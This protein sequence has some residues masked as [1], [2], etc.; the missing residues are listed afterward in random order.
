M[1]ANPD[2]IIGEKWRVAEEVRI[3]PAVVQ[4]NDAEPHVLH[5]MNLKV[6][7]LSKFSK[8]VRFHSP[9][10]K[11]FSLKVKN[12]D[13]PI[14][15]GLDVTV[16]VEYYTEDFE[17]R[18]DRTILLVDDD[19][20]EIPLIAFTPS[21][22]LEIRGAVDFG[23]TVLNGKIL[24]GYFSIDNYGS[25]EGA[26]SI[27]YTGKQSLTIIP[28]SDVIRAHSSLKIKVEFIGKTC[29]KFQ[30]IINVDL[31]R[32][33]QAHVEVLANVV[34]RSCKLEIAVSATA[35]PVEVTITP[36]PK[37]VFGEC[38]VGDHVEALCKITNH[39]HLWRDKRTACRKILKIRTQ[40]TG[41]QRYTYIDP[42]FA[43]TDEETRRKQQHRQLYLDY[44]RDLRTFREFKLNKR[45]MDRW[46]NKK[47][48]GIK[49]GHGLQ[50][51]KITVKEANRI[52]KNEENRCSSLDAMLTTKTLA[53]PLKLVD[54]LN[55]IP[56]TDVEKLD[57]KK[58]L[59]PEDIKKIDIGKFVILPGIDFGEVCQR[60]M[61]TKYLTI[62]NNLN[63]HIHAVVHID[64]RELRQSSPLSQVIPPHSSARI[65]LV[66]ESIA[67]GSFE[68]NIQY[69]IN[70]NQH[71]YVITKASVVPVA[72]QLS[73]DKLTL[74]PNSSM[75]TESGFRGVVRIDN[76]RNAD[77]DF[78][79]K[80]VDCKDDSSF[81][82]C[83]SRGTVNASS[84]LDCEVVFHP[85]YGSTRTVQY[86]FHVEGGK[87]SRLACE[88]QF[89]PT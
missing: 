20:I 85:S 25:R 63:Q 86:N 69:T 59:S 16:L 3:F 58:T 71:F 23:T 60:S 50:P 27:K 14:A 28:T 56:L 84:S 89:G 46:E 51:L 79:W 34:E 24:T 74:K 33:D 47:D 54:G 55:A 30:E 73:S 76:R 43:L 38:K 42:D 21:P 31:E 6:Q 2:E 67:K 1:V 18:Q 45:K 57:C 8:F 83:P 12:P 32:Q 10:S 78:A 75:A 66:F 80:I 70:D 17:D 49:P 36:E 4:F 65:N 41:I 37:V 52:E 72:L 61:K 68:R 77:A 81:S 13:K 62:G 29:G 5:Q 48:L 39:S 22:Q 64:C 15:P 11:F 87:N 9:N 40:Y 19:I 53:T 82:I 7:N 88:A 44:L 26:F 35:A